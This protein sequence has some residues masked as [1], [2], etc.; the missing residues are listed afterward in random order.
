M[1]KDALPWI[2]ILISLVALFVSILNYR[3]DRA[4]LQATSTYVEDWEGFNARLRVDIVNKG[5]RPIIISSWVG[6]A[7]KRK[8]FR[9]TSG[10]N[11]VSHCFVS[12]TEGITLSERQ[13]HSFQLEASELDFELQ[14]G[15]EVTYDDMWIVDTLT[16]RHRIKGIRKDLESLKKWGAKQK[17]PSIAEND[18]AKEFGA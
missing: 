8:F 6:A 15:V 3:R 12:H 17:A 5:R 18:A 2:A 16:D 13:T 10:N 9:R 4:I 14:N 7:T 11:W 1:F